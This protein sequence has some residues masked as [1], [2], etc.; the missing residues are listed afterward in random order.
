MA[1]NG[2]VW[3]EAALVLLQALGLGNRISLALLLVRSL[4]GGHCLGRK[5]PTEYPG[6]TCEM[7]KAGHACLRFLMLFVGF[8]S[9]VD[10]RSIPTTRIPLKG[11]KKPVEILRDRW[12][13]P[14]IYAEDEEDLFFAQGYITA[15]D[16]LFQLD[17]WR[18]I[19]TGKL[20]E[21]LGPGAIPRDRIARLVGYRGDWNAEW[22]SYSPHAKRI[23]E[24]FTNGINAYIR[25]LHGKRPPEFALAGYDPGLWAP[26]DVTARMA[27]LLM[28]SNL[29]ME[30]TRAEQIKQLGLDTVARIFPPDPRIALTI[31][32][33]LDLSS[34]S[35]NI[36]KDYDTAV[37]PIHFPGEQG[38]NNWVID[39]TRS[40]T[41]KPLLAND[42]HRA[43]ELPSLRKTVHLVAPGWNAIG[44]GE[45]ALPG[46]ALGHNDRIAFG[47]TIVGIDQQ[48]LYVEK[49]N[50]EN[51]ALYQYMGAWRP[52]RV[53]HEN[54]AVKG[55]E[56]QVLEL[57]YTVHGPVLYED[58]AKHLAFALKWV[59]AE[60]GSAGYL[61]GLRLA[62]A[63]DWAQFK[64]AVS[65]Y[66]VPTENLVYA[67]P[68]GNIGW[69]ASGLAP[70]R[71]NWS[72]L[73]PVPGDDGKYEWSGFLSIDEH[74]IKFNPPEHYIATANNNI[75]PAGYSHPLS[76]SWAPS[77]RHDRIVEML[78]SRDKFSILDFERMQQDTL[79]LPARKFIAI[80]KTWETKPGSQGRRCKPLF[81]QWNGDMRMDSKEALLYELWANH[82]ER[83][84]FPE[85]KPGTRIDPDVFLRELQ[86]TRNRDELLE[87]SLEEA[88]ADIEKRL[89]PEG[90]KDTWGNLHKVHFD[91]PLG[92]A[93]W[94][95]PPISRPGDAF[96]VNATSGPGFQQTAGASYR[97]IIDVSDWDRSVTTNT[98]G[99]SGNPGSRHYSDLAAD[100][101]AG[102]YHPLPYSRA[103][104]EV[105]AEER[106]VLEPAK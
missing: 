83:L 19:G 29:V 27:G 34:I 2:S 62:Q 88:L 14:H 91:H 63:H 33:G 13:V 71:K 86:A 81:V 47:F 52:M 9:M 37:T 54:L 79:S 38:S 46:I 56:T 32:E 11:L 74:P 85:I 104:V 31:P 21:V 105:A 70:V 44:A 48:D 12:G 35:S 26:E 93:A 68:D 106:I 3:L 20:A 103:A 15:A 84:V 69:I 24:S 94:N 82:L 67:D 101:A 51:P 97:E 57:R 39:G 89:G 80:V 64:D 36:V 53:E 58:P 41:G 1:G 40:E 98:P 78:G 5:S 75:L 61:A 16:R 10:S 95:V 50:P 73:L 96:T 8:V 99:E 76:Y 66:K 28:T 72:G 92:H 6:Y 7:R 23:A 22:A 30:V 42:P 4:T 87:R 102:R 100:W 18:R 43:I 49:L 65:Y 90:A 59:G 17:L 77:A 25:S 55:Q 45:P 60:P